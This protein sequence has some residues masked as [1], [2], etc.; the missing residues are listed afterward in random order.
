MAKTDD[1]DLSLKVGFDPNTEALEAEIEKAVGKGIAKGIAN[2]RN[3]AKRQNL[4][5][6][7]SDAGGNFD[8]FNAAAAYHSGTEA[9]IQ[10]RGKGGLYAHTG[11]VSSSVITQIQRENEATYTKFT[12]S[13]QYNATVAKHIPGIIDSD[14]RDDIIAAATL[15]DRFKYTSAGKLNPN[16]T[17]DAAQWAKIFGY[18]EAANILSDPNSR[19]GRI[20]SAI[21][22][23]ASRES[24]WADMDE[25]GAWKKQDFDVLDAAVKAGEGRWKDPDS[26]HVVDNF[27]IINDATQEENKNLEDWRDNLKGIIGDLGI[28]ALLMKGMKAVMKFDKWAEQT[29]KTTAEGLP[30]RSNIGATSTDLYRMRSASGYLN[31]DSNAIYDSVSALAER[32]G[33]FATTGQGLELFYGSVAQG[34]EPILK[35]MNDPIEAWNQSMDL[36]LKELTALKEAGDQQGIDK[37]LNSI[38]KFM[39]GNAKTILSRIIDYNFDSQTTNDI[40]NMSALYDKSFDNPY[41]WESE[42][43]EAL[44]SELNTLRE[45]IKASYNAIADDWEATFGVRFKSWWNQF[46][47][48]FIAWYRE[49]FEKLRESPNAAGTGGA[50]AFVRGTVKNI[51]KTTP[52][53]FTAKDLAEYDSSPNGRGRSVSYKRVSNKQEAEALYKSLPAELQE[54]V[55]SFTGAAGMDFNDTFL[56]NLIM[57]A[58]KERN[59]AR[60]GPN[61][62]QINQDRAK[63]F[64][65]NVTAKGNTANGYLGYWLSSNPDVAEQLGI[66]ND[67]AWTQEEY[68]KVM[69]AYESIPEEYKNDNAKYLEWVKSGGYQE[70]LNERGKVLR[71]YKGGT[72]KKFSLKTST[73][74]VPYAQNAQKATDFRN[75]LYEHSGY[76]DLARAFGEKESFLSVLRTNAGDK[77]EYVRD[78][79]DARFENNPELLKRLRDENVTAFENEFASSVINLVTGN[80]SQ[81]EILQGLNALVDNLAAQYELNVGS[82]EDVES[83]KATTKNGRTAMTNPTINITVNGVDTNNAQEVAYAVSSELKPAYAAQTDSVV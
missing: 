25:N 82:E 19:G 53:L 74:V 29:V 30:T 22:F 13:K 60:T 16:A 27:E 63:A 76:T 78:Y 20:I 9:P 72:L 42:R 75:K 79:L 31:L 2:I 50:D 17:K 70:W 81:S 68:N 23:A 18:D 32:Q 43:S 66:K 49:D 64:I 37:L 34:L 26:A 6:I 5:S 48:D 7:I 3:E 8:R 39:G 62:K 58:D 51:D 40:K 35:N 71:E 59:T 36:F 83:V 33:E 28:I 15:H 65:K 67:H 57:A 80:Y 61:T 10:L 4:T 55:K 41:A 52:I 45:S 38:E 73:G 1:D 44:N 46:L 54:A 24:R 11:N 12:G 14:E 56:W 77:Y 69:G 47:I 21:D